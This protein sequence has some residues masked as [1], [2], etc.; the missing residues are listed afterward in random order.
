MK[1]KLMKKN[2]LQQD[3]IHITYEKE[4]ADLAL[5][6]AEP[7][8]LAAAE[9]LKHLDKKQIAEIKVMPNPPL[10]VVSVMQCVLELKP[11]AN[12]NPNDKWAGS[13]KM[14]AD[15]NFIKSLKEY[16][17]DLITDK[18]IKNIEKIIKKVKD[19]KQKLTIENLKR[20][21]DSA[22]GLFQW[23]QAILH[24]HSIF[25]VK[26]RR[27]KVKKMELKMLKAQDNL[28]KIQIKLSNL[29]LEIK[30][31]KKLYAQQNIELDKLKIEAKNM[32]NFLL[33]ASEL[34]HNLANENI[35]W[36][37]QVK[38]LK[39]QTSLLIGDCL[40]AASFLSYTSAFNYQYRQKMLLNDYFIHLKKK[41]FMKK[42]KV[43][44]RGKRR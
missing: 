8:L 11:V 19:P 10:A 29:Q 43:M 4:Q 16:K 27:L 21:S 35:R 25:Q 1:N 40:L 34:I 7:A 41:I 42:T 44:L 2:K 26:P 36:N 17:K 13:K 38:R 5:K 32:E 6:Q 31:I 20:I 18:Q 12:C 30:K 23:I 24:Y 9:A 3:G 14:M 33:I 28:N 22:L 15:V 39:Q 37:K